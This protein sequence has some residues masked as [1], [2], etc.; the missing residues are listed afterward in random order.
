MS[1][2]HLARLVIG[3]QDTSTSP[4]SYN[5]VENPSGNVQIGAT[6][7]LVDVTNFSDTDRRYIAGLSDGEEFTV[8]CYRTHAA[9]S[10]QNSL[11]TSAQNKTNVVLRITITDYTV[12]PNTTDQYQFTAVPTRWASNSPNPGEAQMI[13]FSFKIS[14]SIT[15]S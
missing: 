14:G 10:V 6:N 8:E 9:S 13:M 12:S 7:P 3:V 2:E 1:G 5:N 4:I 11:R 15:V